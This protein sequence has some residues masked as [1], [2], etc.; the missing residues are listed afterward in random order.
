[1]FQKLYGKKEI[2][3]GVGDSTTEEITTTQEFTTTE[4]ITTTETP[5]HPNVKRYFD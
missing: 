3:S 5:I 4:E 1:M 2:D